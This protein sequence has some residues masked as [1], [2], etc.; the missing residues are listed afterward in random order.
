MGP[1]TIYD[2]VFE[3]A[4]GM[5]DVEAISHAPRNIKQV[6]NARAKLKRAGNDEDEFYSLLALEKEM[7]GSCIKGLQWTPSPRVVYI[8][9]W[10]IAEIVENCCQPDSTCVL[11]IDTTF[12]VGQFYV[13]STTYQ[14]AKFVNQRTGTLTNLLGPALFHVRQ[15]ESQ[16]LFFCNN[17]LKTNYGFEKV[18]FV[19]G[20]FLKPLKGVT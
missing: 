16:F 3:E 2:K 9:D 20:E 1:S 15:D 12:N 10:Q 11:S 6:K 17:L 4:G 8:E 13:T 18:R 5:L 19:G 14:N 7:G